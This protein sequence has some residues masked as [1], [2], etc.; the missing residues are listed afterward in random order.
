MRKFISVFFVGSALWAT[1]ALAGVVDLTPGGKYTAND[2][3]VVNCTAQ[4]PV[5]KPEG[6][7]MYYQGYS[8]NAKKELINACD[9]T[10]SQLQC[11]TLDDMHGSGKD[12]MCLGICHLKAE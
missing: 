6:V 4:T 11:R 7:I 10:L 9:G 5:P 1:A 2:G 12:Y 3:T 8:F